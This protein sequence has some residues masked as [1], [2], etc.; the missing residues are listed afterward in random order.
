MAI[1]VP[2][3]R[4][5]N[6]RRF[7]TAMA[8]A[9]AAA[10]FIGFAP[11][12][13]LAAWND[14]P[15][16]LLTPSIHIH[17]ALCT[18]WIALLAIQTGLI[19]ARRPDIHKVT[20]MVG[21]VLGAAILVTGF[22]VA[23]G[24]E[25]RVHTAANAGT[26]AD[27]YVFL[28]FPMSAVGLFALFAIIGV[29]S[30]RQPEFHKRFMLLATMSLLGPALARIATQAMLSFSAPGTTFVSVP[31]A[32]AALVLVDLFL[33]ALV[34]YDLTT[35]GRLHPA[36]LWGGGFLLVSQPLRVMIAHSQPWQDFARMLMT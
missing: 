22:F 34:I 31:G 1:S 20:G 17:G 2:Q 25:R 32:I 30:R 19:A 13:Y 7:F 24:S 36:T 11:T 35:R 3:P 16:P 15:R 8:L 23:I 4:V 12:Y 10:T 29:A 21:V 9:M 18:A 28:I 5:L 6:D 14:A 33:A 26:L 27:P